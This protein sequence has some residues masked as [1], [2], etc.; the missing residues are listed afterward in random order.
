[1]SRV[2]P[3]AQKAVEIDP[4]DS[5]AAK[6]SCPTTSLWAGWLTCQ[7]G[8]GA[9]RKSWDLNSSTDDLVSLH[10]CPISCLG[11]PQEV[12]RLMATDSG[13]AGRIS[14]YGGAGATRSSIPASSG[15]RQIPCSGRSS[16]Q[17]APRRQMQQ[18]GFLLEGSGQPRGLAG[19]CNANEEVRQALSLDKSRQT[20][21]SAALSAALCGDG[22]LAMPSA[23]E[24]E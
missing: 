2:F 13:P 22:K 6:T 24:V 17:R 21:A 1:M 23:S 18:A 10:G 15:W 11:Q 12:Q 3:Y 16:K 5:I 14:G 9:D 20:Q 4:Q 19:L 7:E 8:V